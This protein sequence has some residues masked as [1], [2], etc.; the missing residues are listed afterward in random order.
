MKQSAPVNKIAQILS[1]LVV[2]ILILLPFHAFLTVW[3]SSGLD[4][5]TLLRLWK[6]FL[7][8]PIALG[9]LYF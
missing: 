2:A 1:W 8:L 7:L 4:H 6:E 3:L 9:A 5:Y